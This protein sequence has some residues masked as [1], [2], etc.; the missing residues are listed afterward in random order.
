[1]FGKEKIEAYQEITAPPELKSRIL[2]S[3]KRAKAVTRQRITFAATAA[4]F[5]L[6]FVGANVIESQSTILSIGDK[7]VTRRT[8]HVEEN[9]GIPVAAKGAKDNNIFLRIPLGIEADGKTHI[10]VNVGALED[11][12]KD[13]DISEDRTV[14]WILEGNLTKNPICTIE[15]KNREYQYQVEIQGNGYIIRRIK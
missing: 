10:R 14:D 5:L 9:I 11:D 13:M 4:S 8:L 1:M 3:V 15:T 6:L 12:T 7:A 2:Q